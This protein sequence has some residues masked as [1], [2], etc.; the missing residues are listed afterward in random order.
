MK[1][2]SFLFSIALLS[3]ASCGQ[4][5][6]NFDSEGAPASGFTYMWNAPS[7]EES[8]SPQPMDEKSTADASESVD[9]MLAGSTTTMANANSTGTY[10]VTKGLTNGVT[11]V[12]APVKIA[13]KIKKTA[14]IDISVDDYKVARAAIDK[15]I[16][17][18]NGYIGGEQEQNSTYS[19]SNSM[20]IRVSNKDFD[21]M[22]SNLS[23]IASHVNSKNIYMEDVTAQFVDITARLKTKKEVEKRYLALL[24]KAVKVTDILEVEEQLRV[25]RE[26]IEAKEGEL[27]YLNDQVDYS[28]INL[29]F[30]QNFEYTPED[31]PGFFGRIG[32]AFGNGWKGFL[33]FLIGVVYA[34]PL[35][36]ILGL[37]A[38]FTVKYVK[39]KLKK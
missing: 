33:S 12:S 28:T 15:I 7:A 31:E 1:Q 25:I 38:Y 27:K 22:V 6:S 11:Q 39:K 24:D 23:T 4:K 32:H 34:W 8:A 18:G 19:I 16:K 5:S 36:M 35:W 20:I 13:E 29:N 17:S 30:H 14:N 3:L 37:V 2:L 21:A 9:K 26:E 10:T